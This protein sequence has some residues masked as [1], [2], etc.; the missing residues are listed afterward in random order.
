MAI[1]CANQLSKD[2]VAVR[3][4][5]MPSQELFEQQNNEYKN[6]ILDKTIETYVSIEAQSEQG[7]HKYIGRDGIC[8]SVNTF[9]HSAPADELEEMYGF[10]VEQIITKIKK[11]QA[12]YAYAKHTKT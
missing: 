5:S 11:H 3:V 9:G 4:I 8:I 1:K 12:S 10:K 7:W 6:R 2:D